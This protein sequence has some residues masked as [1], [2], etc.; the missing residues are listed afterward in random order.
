M[1]T[2]IYALLIGGIAALVGGGSSSGSTSSSPASAPE[3]DPIAPAA[4]LQILPT[5]LTDPVAV[6]EDAPEEANAPVSSGVDTGGN[7]GSNVPDLPSSAF[8][9]GWEGLNAEEQMIVELV[10][11]ARLDPLAEVDRLND[12]LAVGSSS[13]PVQ[14]LAATEALSEAA[15]D[16]S[17]DMDNRNFFAHTNLDGESP[18]DRAIE[19]GHGSRF[20]GENI[21]W[22][23]SSRT[24]ADV[25]ARAEAHHENLWNSDGHQ[26]N[27]LRENWS[28]TGAGYDYGSHQGFNGSTFVTELFSDRGDTYLTGVVIDDNDDDAFYDIGEGQGGVQITAFDGEDAFATA[29]WDAGGYSLA[30]PP[31]TY[32]VVFEGGDLDA[33]YETDVTIGN[34][35]VKLDVIETDGAV[36]ASLNAGSFLPNLS[37]EQTLA[38]VDGVETADDLTED[39][40]FELV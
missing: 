39:D 7:T 16:H 22:I 33:P 18:A 24:P 23:G 1:V 4:P 31:G 5:V 19:A 12:D 27:L 28:E 17:E 11:R 26:V 6:V 36:V 35:N 14:A 20:V 8:D 21:G 15:R 25:Q 38:W 13:S 40:L 32:R 30:L 9:L 37:A 3:A 34:D 29:T 2:A 10:N